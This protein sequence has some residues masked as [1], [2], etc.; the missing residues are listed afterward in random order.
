MQPGRCGFGLYR[1][2]PVLEQRAEKG[3][4]GTALFTK[5]EPLSVAYGI[6]ALDDEEG[7]VIT[8][9]Y[10]RFLYGNPLFAERAPGACQD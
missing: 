10:P 3:Y 8:A 5:A 2:S 6:D 7:R 4:S 1:L 9:E